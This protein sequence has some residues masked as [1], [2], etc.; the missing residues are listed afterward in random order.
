M[1]EATRSGESRPVGRDAREAVEADELDE[2]LDLRL[3]AA[4]RHPA[5]GLAQAPGDHR[6]VHHQRRVGERQLREVHEQIAVGGERS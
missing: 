3:R 5:P 4:Q 2:P 1:S 6:E